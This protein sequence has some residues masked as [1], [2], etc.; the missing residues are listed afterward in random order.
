MIWEFATVG[1]NSFYVKAVTVYRYSI[2]L[3]APLGSL[4]FANLLF[5]VPSE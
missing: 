4:L 2:M 3:L 1:N 5:L